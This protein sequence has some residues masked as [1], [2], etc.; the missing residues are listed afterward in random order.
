MTTITRSAQLTKDAETILCYLAPTKTVLE[1]HKRAIRDACHLTDARR[2]D[3]AF[4]ELVAGGYLTDCGE[5]IFDLTESGLT[6]ARELSRASNGPVTNIHNHIERLDGGQVTMGGMQDVFTT[7]P[8]YQPALKTPS[9]GKLPAVEVKTPVMDEAEI[10]R[11]LDRVAPA[12][13]LL[14]QHP[15]RNGVPEVRVA[16]GAKPPRPQPVRYLMAFDSPK[17]VLPIPIVSG[18]V[19]GR[20]RKGTIVMR[21]D[22]YI[23]NR[24]CRFEVARDKATGKPCLYVEDLG[25]R[26]G[27][28]VDDI[29]VYD[30]KVPLHHGSRLRVGDT[31]LV[32]I[33]IP[34]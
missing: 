18:D 21:H 7:P 6:L 31:V 15:L 17:D 33:E 14:L 8:A 24:H 1:R 4:N 16:K 10:E 22:E 19:L 9:T 26:N 13:P 11:T 30:A 34:F 29:E 27:T 23:S 32:V 25:S 28:F 5:G 20:S 12:L 2:A 3:K